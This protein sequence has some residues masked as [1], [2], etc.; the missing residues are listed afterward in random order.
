MSKC[1]F[2]PA[3]FQFFRRSCNLSYFGDFIHLSAFYFL[4]IRFLVPQKLM[5]HQY[6][7]F[8]S[9]LANISRTTFHFISQDWLVSLFIAI[10]PITM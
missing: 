3:F 5:R 6:L 8:F 1:A 9:K 2:F 4:E 7:Q 10:L